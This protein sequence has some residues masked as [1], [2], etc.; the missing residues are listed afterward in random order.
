MIFWSDR[1]ITMS[2]SGPGTGPDGDILIDNFGSR[3]RRVSPQEAESIR[4]QT[5][6]IIYTIG[7][8]GRVR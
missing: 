7:P 8:D 3:Y 2:Q 1:Y 5:A 6:G 4:Q